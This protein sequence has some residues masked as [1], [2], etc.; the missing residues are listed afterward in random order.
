MQ[1]NFWTLYNLYAFGA[2]HRVWTD[3]LKSFCC[4]CLL[5]FFWIHNRYSAEKS[6]IISLFIII[7]IIFYC[8][9]WFVLQKAHDLNILKHAVTVFIS[10]TTF[11][12][13]FLLSKHTKSINNIRGGIFVSLTIITFVSLIEIL[14]GIRLPVSRYFD[15]SSSVPTGFY[16]N[17]N[18]LGIILWAIVVSLCIMCRSRW[19]FLSLMA[20][21]QL[22]IMT[23]SRII[24]VLFI[25]TTIYF[26]IDTLWRGSRLGGPQPWLAVVGAALAFELIAASLLRDMPRIILV[27]NAA[28]AA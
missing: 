27:V 5:G 14:F 22:G 25:V 17:E 20:A 10:L 24:A 1:Y 18:N 26:V 19:S 7:A 21:S 9:A 13:A 23:G 15:L 28:L 12:G 8:L 4:C 16:G 3:L 11:S 6:D 2:R